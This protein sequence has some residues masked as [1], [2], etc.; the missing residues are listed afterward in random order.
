MCFRRIGKPRFYFIQGWHILKSHHCNFLHFV[1]FLPC[2]ISLVGLSERLHSA[3]TALGQCN[4]CSNWDH[5]FLKLSQL[6]SLYSVAKIE[7]LVYSNQMK[8][9]FSSICRL[10]LSV[11]SCHIRNTGFCCFSKECPWSRV[12]GVWSRDTER[13]FHQEQKLLHVL[14]PKGQREMQQSAL[15]LLRCIYRTKNWEQK[16]ILAL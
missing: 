11:G 15:D 1:P 7:F 4:M 5:P 9:L 6:L 16:E 3:V 2:H 14:E 10:T 13:A 8:L 12:A